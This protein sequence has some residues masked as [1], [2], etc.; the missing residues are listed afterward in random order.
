MQAGGKQRSASTPAA[1]LSLDES[2]SDV[3]LFLE[4]LIAALRTTFD[5]ACEQTLALIISPK[6]PSL[7]VITTSLLM[8]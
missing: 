2:D 1:W 6:R 5:G 7:K 3:M 8:K 4:Y